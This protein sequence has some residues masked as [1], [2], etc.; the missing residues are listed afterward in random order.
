L[1]SAGFDAH[2]A[3]HI[4]NSDD[5]AITEYEYKWCTEQL[6]KIANRFSEGR[7]VSILEGGYS[8]KAGPISPLA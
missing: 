5:T 1:V 3:D 6:A 2:Q 7:I 4:H 8:T